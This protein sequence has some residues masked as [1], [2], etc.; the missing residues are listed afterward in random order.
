MTARIRLGRLPAGCR[1]DRLPAGSLPQ[2]FTLPRAAGQRI[3][4]P[5]LLPQ[6]NAFIALAVKESQGP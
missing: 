2:R 6:A 1:L 4:L 5:R 3:P